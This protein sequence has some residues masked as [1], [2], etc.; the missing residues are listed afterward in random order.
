[1][2]VLSYQWMVSLPHST[3]SRRN[4]NSSFSLSRSLIPLISFD[5]WLIPLL[6]R[7]TGRSHTAGFCFPSTINHTEYSI[8]FT[9]SSSVLAGWVMFLL[10]SVELQGRCSLRLLSEE[11]LL[12][13]LKMTFSS[14][15]LPCSNRRFVTTTWSGTPND[16]SLYILSPCTFI[17]RPQ[18]GLK[19]PRKKITFF[20]VFINK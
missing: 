16:H 17:D 8:S 13:Q 14:P 4:T 12:S 11:L 20:F 15:L 3:V 2:R 19:P 5:M 18:I 9:S 6:F 10:S 7:N 1:M